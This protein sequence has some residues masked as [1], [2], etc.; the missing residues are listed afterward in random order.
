[1]CFSPGKSWADLVD[2]EGPRAAESALVAADACVSA[3][4]SRF[5]GVFSRVVR[6]VPAEIICESV[7]W[8]LSGEIDSV[9]IFFVPL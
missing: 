5:V 6:G 4:R 8:K 3:P 7:G 1:M 2:D 9:Q